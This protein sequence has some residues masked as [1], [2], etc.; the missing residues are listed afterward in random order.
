M[1]SAPQNIVQGRRC[2]G[3]QTDLRHARRGAAYAL[4]GCIQGSTA[5]ELFTNVTKDHPLSESTPVGPNSSDGDDADSDGIQAGEGLR[6]EVNFRP[7]RGRGDRRWVMSGLGHGV[8][9]L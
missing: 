1:T 8:L 4:A 2:G 3:S 7:C 9:G 6:Q 5:N